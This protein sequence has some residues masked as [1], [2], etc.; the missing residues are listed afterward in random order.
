MAQRN[1]LQPGLRRGVVAGVLAALSSLRFRGAPVI[2]G[3]QAI[4]HGPGFVPQPNWL[5]GSL[6]SQ[7][8]APGARGG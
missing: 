7:K 1:S 2:P 8:F 3:V 5:K 4:G 6:I